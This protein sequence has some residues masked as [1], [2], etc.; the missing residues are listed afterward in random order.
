MELEFTGPNEIV[1]KRVPR[2]GYFGITAFPKSTTT[3]GCELS[4]NGY[5]TGLTTEQEKYYEQALGLKA[6][7]LSK[8]SKWWGEIFNIDYSIRL[9]NTKETRL[10]LDDKINQLKYYSLNASSKVANS[11]IDKKEPWV[12]FYIVDEEAKAKAESEQ[13]DYEWEA[14]ELLLKLSPEEKRASLRLFGKKGVD[15]LTELM[16]KSELTKEL[17]KDPK[18]F[19][20]VLKDKALKIRMLIEEMIEYKVIIRSGNYYKN[21]DDTIASSTDEVLEY[22]EDLKNQSVVL[23]LTTRLKKEKKNK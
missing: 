22:F 3:L 7:E 8:H 20:E 5:K 6:G 1:I 9:N 10:I 19:C 13:F 4:K 17:K 16:L 2:A 21:G 12:D 15:S 11:E 23:A 18:A 14:M